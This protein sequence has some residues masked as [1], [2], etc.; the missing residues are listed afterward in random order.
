MKPMVRIDARWIPPLWIGLSAAVSA[1]LTAGYTCVVPFAALGVAAAMTLPR[2]E[3]VVCTLVVWLAN[4]AAGFGLMGYPWTP[5]TMG[6][7]A[8]IGVAALAGTLAAQWLRRSLHGWRSSLQAVTVFVVAFALYESIL[9]AA[10]ITMLGG[11]GAFAP[12]IMG[13]VLGVNVVALG[14]LWALSQLLTVAVSSY[15]RRV[16]ASPARFA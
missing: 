12:A 8:V 14:G 6:W 5:S 15:R 16:S 2:R 10:A 13:H 7:G 1:M 3:A 11:T 9:Y 4:Q